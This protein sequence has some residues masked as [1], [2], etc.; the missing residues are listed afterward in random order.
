[1]ANGFV[2]INVKHQPEIEVKLNPQERKEQ[3]TANG[4]ILH[5]ISTK[6][7]EDERKRDQLKYINVINEQHELPPRK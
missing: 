3:F 6:L 4:P 7:R 1:M 5:D 2:T